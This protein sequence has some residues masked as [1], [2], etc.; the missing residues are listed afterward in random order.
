MYN[1]MTTLLLL[2][3]LASMTCHHFPFFLVIT[4]LIYMI[5]SLTFLKHLL[6]VEMLTSS[7]DEQ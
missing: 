2:V 3:Q 6:L 4:Y 1:S 7:G 5:I